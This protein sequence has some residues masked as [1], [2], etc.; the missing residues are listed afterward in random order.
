MTYL[1][2]AIGQSRGRAAGIRRPVFPYARVPGVITI[3]I[4]HQVI[5]CYSLGGHPGA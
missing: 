3:G 1:I 2:G 5:S 4:D